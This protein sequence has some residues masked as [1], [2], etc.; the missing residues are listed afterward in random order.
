ME[1]SSTSGQD[2][3]LSSPIQIGDWD[4]P[5]RFIM[6]P[7]TRCRASEARVPNVLMAEY[8]AQRATA[9]LIISEA[10][11]VTPMGVGYPNTPGIWSDA[12]VDRWK[13]V[14]EAV[15]KA[16]GRIICHLW[17]VVP[18]SDPFYLNGEL[19]V[20]PSPIAPPGEVSLIRPKKKFVTPRALELEE[21]PGVIEAYR[22]GAENALKA[23]FDGVELHGANGYLLD[24]FLQDST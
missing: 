14:T 13:L 23:G 1:F 24:Q 6:A 11:S 2:K 21:I 15:H 16:G 8:Y 10:T 18:I 17:H 7:L 22:T 19:P 5:N 4:L 20:S 12:Q 3:I 9:G